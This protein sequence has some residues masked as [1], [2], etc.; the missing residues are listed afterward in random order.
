MGYTVYR[1]GTLS[2]PFAIVEI[3]FFKP[4]MERL[5]NELHRSQGGA[6][7]ITIYNTTGVN[8]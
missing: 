5:G 8:S 1:F 4:Y 2:S 7:E 6:L 3:K